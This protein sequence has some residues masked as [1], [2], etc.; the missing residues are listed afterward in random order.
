MGKSS[1]TKVGN[2]YRLALHSCLGIGEIDAYLEMRAADKTAWRGELTASGRI[3]VNEPEL[4]GGESDQGGVS[5]TAH[6][7]FGEP[8]QV[9]S[10]YLLG[11]G[12]DQTAA[13]RGFLT[14]VWEGGRWGAM[15]PFPHKPAHKVR[16]IIKGWDHE[17]GCWYP[18]KAEITLSSIEAPVDGPWKYRVEAP[19]SSADYSAADVDDS[20]WD[21][22]DGAFGSQVP[23]GSGMTIGTPVPGQL[24]KAIWIRREID[25]VGTLDL[26]IYHDDGA[27]LWLNGTP[28]ALESVSYFHSRATAS[29]AGRTTIAMQVIDGVP[30]GSPNIFAGIAFYGRGIAAVAMNAAHALYYVRNDSDKGRE[31]RDNIDDANLRAAADR[32]H[33]E[34]F[35]LCWIYDPA[36]ETPDAWCERI[37]RI[38]GGSFQRSIVDGKWRLH[39]V[40]DDYD[41]EA[42]P[43]FSDAN[44]VILSVREVPSSLYGAVNVVG[45]QYFD[46]ERKEALTVWARAPGLVA[47][48]GEVKE[49]FKF[50]EIPTGA[51]AA[52]VA[53]RLLREYITPTRSWEIA[54][55][56]EAYRHIDP[57]QTVRYQ[58]PK[59]GIDDMVCIIGEKQGGTLRSG[60][61]RWV[62]TQHV[63]GFADA[64]YVEIEYGVD[65]RPPDTP[66]PVAAAAVYEAPYVDVCAALPRAEL[67]ALPDDVGYLCAVA[68]DPGAGIDYSLHVQP[69]GGDYARVA[70]GDW[71]PTATVVGVVPR[72][73]GP[74]VV[75]LANASHLAQAAVGQAIILGD[76][77]CRLDALDLDAMTATLG[78]GCADTVPAEHADGARLWVIGDAVAADVTEYTDGEEI[79]AKP[80]PRTGSRQLALEDATAMPI[81]FAG[82]QARPYPPAGLQV[83]G[84]SYPETV[85]GDAVLAWAHRDRVLQ[86]D[87]LVDQAMASIGPEPGTT[88]IVRCVDVTTDAETH[89]QDGI[90]GTTHTVPA[91]DLA[92][93]SRIEVYSIRDGLESWQRAAAVV[94]LGALLLDGHGAP[95][96]DNSDDPIR[97]S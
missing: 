73:A 45:V 91:V 11:L 50:R 43:V 6:V 86:A 82:R 56:P 65:T 78:R 25:F 8:A 26:D 58:D 62:L 67:D 54:T 13:W 18:E 24:G 59:R 90:T 12:R 36:N 33:A 21:V 4:F 97:M 61:I 88:Y 5:G 79:D 35:G 37:G 81:E 48:F 41:L 23:S 31:S 40:R 1:K 57:G 19:G 14:W 3:T 83:N 9:P 30:G 49:L 76:E 15:N 93:L 27:W 64:A 68:A 70:G 55:E 80:L 42:L 66:L 22:G 94:A 47:Q 74:T 16:K 29:V 44:G 7:M 10:P 85:V 60:A 53:E 69:A 87:Q 28:V 84:E 20:G 63:Y 32:L 51:L 72:E 2:H 34:G 46:V 92:A 96:T 77:W 75:N 17:E 71:C 39:L 52:R 38:I 95:I 89:Y